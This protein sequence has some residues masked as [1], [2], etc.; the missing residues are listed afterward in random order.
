MR[1]YSFDLIPNYFVAWIVA[2]L[3]VVTIGTAVVARIKSPLIRSLFTIVVAIAAVLAGSKLLYVVERSLFP[4]DD[5]V[6]T[7]LRSAAH[8]FRIPGGILALPLVF[9]PVCALLG[10]SWR[11]LGDAL[12]PLVA[13]SL[14]FVRIGCFLNGC[15]FG[16]ITTLPWA[17][18]FPHDSWAY[19]YHR[20]HGWLEP[21]AQSSLLVHPLQLY[22]VGAAGALFLI[23]TFLR[24]SRSSAPGQ[25]QLIFY[26][27]FFASTAA[28]E[29]LRQNT[30]TL[31]QYL[32]PVAAFTFSILLLASTTPINRERADKPSSIAGQ[33]GLQD[34]PRRHKC[35]AS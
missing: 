21:T 14:V 3:V 5:Y 1:P 25:L 17:V 29:P 18:P 11:S 10:L 30:L 33:P 31:N 35:I 6:P 2:V 20:Q 13:I 32:A 7:S 34:T 15:C 9:V 26:L 24:N 4:L 27:L 8:G 12:V 22:F 28:L 19:W 16:R 23:V